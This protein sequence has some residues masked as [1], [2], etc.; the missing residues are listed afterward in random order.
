MALTEGLPLPARVQLERR[1]INRRQ[2]VAVPRSAAESPLR[3]QGLLCEAGT[4]AKAMQAEPLSAAPSRRGCRGAVFTLCGLYK[5][6][7]L[8]EAKWRARP[9]LVS[10]RSLPR[11]A[12]AAPGELAA[13]FSPSPRVPQAP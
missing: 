12:H 9:R 10:A 5:L 1:R 8:W 7:K 13:R 11:H 2:A 3:S 6:A 4:L